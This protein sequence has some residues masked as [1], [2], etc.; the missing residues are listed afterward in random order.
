M[1]AT[2]CNLTRSC[3]GNVSNARATRSRTWATTSQL[4]EEIGVSRRTLQRLLSHGL[5]Q[6][7]VHWRP[8]NPLMERSPRLWHRERVAKL[9]WADE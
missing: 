7:Q 9:L 2:A 5:F 6:K 3:T 8:I 1:K 4:A